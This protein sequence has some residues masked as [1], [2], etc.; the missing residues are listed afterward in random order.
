MSIFGFVKETKRR[1]RNLHPSQRSFV[2]PPCPLD[3]EPDDPDSLARMLRRSFEID[4]LEVID[5]NHGNGGKS[6]LHTTKAG[7]TIYSIA[8]SYSPDSGMVEE[9]IAANGS[10]FDAANLYIG[11]VMRI[12]IK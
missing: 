4:L 7:E 8:E 5:L 12:P 6:V 10:L 2:T 3:S 9:I 1:K 11:Q